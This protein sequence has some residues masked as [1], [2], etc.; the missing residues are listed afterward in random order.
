MAL[1]SSGTK[2]LAT[3]YDRVIPVDSDRICA[4]EVTWTDLIIY[5]IGVYRP[6]Q[7]C[8]IASF[9]HHLNILDTVVEQCRQQDEAIIIGD[10]TVHWGGWNCK[11]FL[12]QDLYEWKEIHRHLSE[13]NMHLA[14]GMQLCSGPQYTFN[15]N[16]VRQSYIHHCSISELYIQ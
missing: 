3:G 2:T 12:W 13:H 8:K 11:S 16:G 14:D 15:I 7:A 9:N 4:I 10:Y 1:L 5:V 6:Q